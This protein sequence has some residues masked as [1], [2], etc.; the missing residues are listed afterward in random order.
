MKR[1]RQRCRFTALWHSVCHGIAQSG[2]SVD[3]RQHTGH[4]GGMTQQSSATQQA[5]QAA[6]DARRA[7]LADASQWGPSTTLEQRVAAAQ[8]ALAVELT[9]CAEGV[10]AGDP[11]APET[12]RALLVAATRLAAALA[13]RA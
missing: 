11:V 5:R 9:R 4:G 8:A 10:E 7:V 1:H 13:A 2:D 12:A 3:R 6:Y